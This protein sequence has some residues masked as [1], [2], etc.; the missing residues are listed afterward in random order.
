MVSLYKLKL[1]FEIS[2]KSAIIGMLMDVQG[3]A[4]RVQGLRRES[5]GCG[6]SKGLRRGFRVLRVQG[7]G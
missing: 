5:R 4:A 3:V 2:I 1:A 7:L 6:G